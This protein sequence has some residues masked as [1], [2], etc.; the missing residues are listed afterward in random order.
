MKKILLKLVEKFLIEDYTID[1][2]RIE[3]LKL[4]S[5]IKQRKE[6]DFIKRGGKFIVPKNGIKILP[7]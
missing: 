3:T 1:E 7:N 4:I 2:L 5:Y 6:K